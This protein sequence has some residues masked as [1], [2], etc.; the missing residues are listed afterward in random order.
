[1]KQYDLKKSREQNDLFAGPQS[2]FDAVDPELQALL[3]AE[4]IA[5]RKTLNLT[6][7]CNYLSEGVQ[8]ALHPALTHIHSEG[9][10]GKRFHQGQEF[11]DAIE[12]LA[13]ARAKSVFKAQHANVQAYR[14]TMANFIACIAAASTGSRLLGFACDAGGHYTTGS[15]VHVLSELFD[16]HTYSIQRDRLDYQHIRAQARAIKPHILFAGDTSWP[17]D[18]DWFEMRSIAD[19][20]GAVLVADISQTA[21]LV[22]AGVLA[23]PCELAD[24]VTLS[25]YKTLRGPRAALILCK[26]EWASRVDR[27]VFPVCQDGTNIMNTA[28]IAAVLADAAKPDFKVYCRQVLANASALAGALKNL[29]YSLVTGGTLNHGCL[30][31]MTSSG[32]GGNECASTLARANIICNGNIIPNDK[33]SPINPSGLRVG[34]PAI[35]T[36]GMQARDMEQVAGFIH[37][38]LKL[39][40]NTPRL[41]DLSV[42]VSDFRAGFETLSAGQQTATRVNVPEPT[43]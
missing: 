11:A 38:A 13:I 5:Q 6:A 40:N 4:L 8:Q 14:G 7:A 42:Q 37:R 25:T 19:D 32:V 30:I 41:Q 24:I 1:M 35:T 34:T 43:F 3:N 9:Y 15:K 33:G 20:V 29:G 18:W 17:G 12:R 21:G 36:L 23:N 22:A 26:K 28:G 39:A 27:A 31:D 10:P 16:I 2:L